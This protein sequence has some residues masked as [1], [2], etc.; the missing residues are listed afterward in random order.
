ML[1]Q[2]YIDDKKNNNA[3]YNFKDFS[4]DIMST[5]N[6]GIKYDD[7]IALIFSKNIR[8]FNSEIEFETRSCVINKN[9]LEIIS[10]QKNI[11]YDNDAIN[12]LQNVDF[13]N[14]KFS[15][16]MTGT[17]LTVFF[18]E[19]W[20]VCTRR[21]IEA[22]DSIWL[23]K[24]FGQL[25]D[26]TRT[27][28]F[29]DLNKNFIYLF[30]LSSD[31]C[32]ESDNYELILCSVFEKY[33]MKEI[34]DNENIKI[35]KSKCICFNNID[36]VKQHINDLNKIDLRNKKIS[37]DGLIA[38]VCNNGQYC[39]LKIQTD[40]YRTVSDLKNNHRNMNMILLN[41]YHKNLLNEY[42]TYFTNDMTKVYFTCKAMFEFI[43]EIKDIYFLFK[44]NEKNNLF[45]N[46]L[47]KSYKR[48]LYDIHGIFLKTHDKINNGVI[49]NHLR[50]IEFTYLIKLLKDRRMLPYFCLAEKRLNLDN[51][52]DICVNNQLLTNY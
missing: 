4:N 17:L 44:C 20:Y 9:T 50:T 15:E 35:T 51:L 48:L 28:S 26:E 25:F 31:L 5:F 27:F 14:V 39:T 22:H 52:T 49:M 32:V 21:T 42:C 18:Y 19:K 12:L 40:I 13:N 6:I 11:I 36:E 3:L 23:N 37:S 30:V 16:S 7:N 46:T 24:S 1:L 41:L 33:T 43:K 38:R 2:K 47:P 29:D 45:Y 10:Y 34:D 8:N